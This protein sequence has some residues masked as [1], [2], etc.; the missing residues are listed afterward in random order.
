MLLC[1]AA[2][3]SEC[4]PNDG[5]FAKLGHPPL[6]SY[7]LYPVVLLLVVVAFRNPLTQ[8]LL[9]DIFYFMSWCSDNVTSKLQTSP[10]QLEQTP[11]PASSTL[12]TL[13]NLTRTRLCPPS[14]SDDSLDLILGGV[15]LPLITQSDFLLRLRV[16]IVCYRRCLH[17]TY[18]IFLRSF[19]DTSVLLLPSIPS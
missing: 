5:A 15:T 16:F 10:F 14:R 8:R 13:Q 6:S 18:P 17:T 7:F 4:H 19:H 11:P 12:S 9:C 3:D 1:I 2:R